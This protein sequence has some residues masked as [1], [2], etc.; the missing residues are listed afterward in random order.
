MSAA[1]LNKLINRLNGLYDFVVA[2]VDNKIDKNRQLFVEQNQ[3]QLVETGARSDRESV[4]YLFPRKTPTNSSGAYTLP[5]S[6]YKQS[7]GGTTAYVDLYDQGDFNQSIV[8]LKEGVGSWKFS[9]VNVK[10]KWLR[11]AYGDEILGVNDTFLDKYCES[12][13]K[14]HLEKKINNYLFK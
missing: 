10:F 12:D 3:A 9:S 8:L 11:V 14:P 6:R 2:E 5:Y 7:T 13:M 4:E 1:Q